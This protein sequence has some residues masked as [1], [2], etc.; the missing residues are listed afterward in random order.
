[1]PSG[2]SRFTQGGP[3]GQGP[4]EEGRIR[5]SPSQDLKHPQVRLVGVAHGETLAAQGVGE[6]GAE[7]G[8]RGQETPGARATTLP[9]TL[10]RRLKA[11]HD[12]EARTPEQHGQGPEGFSLGDQE[13]RGCDAVEQD[14]RFGEDGPV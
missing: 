11:H 7:Q 8:G 2:V 3:H 9:T 12:G 14:Q 5:G 6:S 4:N 1:M 13:G 10:G